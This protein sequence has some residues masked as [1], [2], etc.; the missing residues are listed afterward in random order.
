MHT[1]L[2][3]YYYYYYYYS[4][5]TRSSTSSRR[6]PAS[7][8]TW[9]VVLGAAARGWKSKVRWGLLD[10]YDVP[11]LERGNV[12]IENVDREAANFLGKQRAMDTYG[13]SLAANAQGDPVI[14]HSVVS[15]AG[16]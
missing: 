8:P 4:C 16:D 14:D 1:K 9:K 7:S 3:Y 6:P 12:G 10:A 5:V 2:Y 11:S 13:D 15:L